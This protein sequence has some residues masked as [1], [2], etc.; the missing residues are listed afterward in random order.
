M[1]RLLLLAAAAATLAVAPPARAADA[2]TKTPIKHF[3]TLM[4]ENHSFDNYFG[5]YPGVNGIPDGTCMPINPE[6]PEDGCVEPERI[7]GRAVQDLSHSFETFK[8]QLR[9]G[10]M[11]GFVSA[12]SAP[13]NPQELAMGYYDDRDLPYYWNIA[14]NYTLFDNHFT[15]ASGGSVANHMYWVAAQPGT[16]TDAIPPEGFSVPTIFDRLEQKNVSWKFYIQN[17]DP[18]ITFR[19]KR[20][21][22]RGSQVVWAP[23]LAYPRFIDNPKLFR[24]IVPMEE[25]YEDMRR[26]TLPAVS[27]LVPSG[28]SE[29]PPGSIKAGETFVRTLINGLMRSPLWEKSA[30][31]WSYDDW[32]GWF[33]HV[34]PPK[35]DR[36]GYGFRAPALLVSPYSRKGYVESR[37]MDF[38][39][40][41]KFIEE[42]WGLKP[43][44]ER[45]RKANSIGLALDFDQAPREA[46]FLSRDRN[47]KPAPKPDRAVVYVLYSLA[48]AFVLALLAA[49]VLVERRRRAPRRLRGD[50][51]PVIID[52]L[53]R[54][55]S[56][57]EEVPR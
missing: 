3:I 56:A 5:T 11:D 42:N 55:R 40:Q 54:D 26:G 48:A 44:A 2:P 9:G 47:V 57:D 51:E 37:T 23:P 27:Y 38:T 21:G 8:A 46:V 35:V 49:A 25:F 43:L 41:L 4:Q 29:H 1:G 24:K 14:D 53:E 45:D 16:E 36:F 13:G 33:D 15:S 31:L 34:R 17:Y 19:S 7:G 12:V 32:G 10:K 18:T 50:S 22:D 6:R 28:A 52:P 20:L 39:S 30:F